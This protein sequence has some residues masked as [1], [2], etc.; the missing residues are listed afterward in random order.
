MA[1]EVGKTRPFGGGILK[2]ELRC[3]V[4]GVGGCSFFGHQLKHPSQAQNRDVTQH[5]PEFYNAVEMVRM[6]CET[7]LGTRFY[8]VIMGEQSNAKKS[9]QKHLCLQTCASLSSRVYRQHESETLPSKQMLIHESQKEKLKVQ[10]PQQKY[11]PKE[12]KRTGKT[13]SGDP[14]RSPRLTLIC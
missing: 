8:F 7:G 4:G 13:V 5:N 9:T 10:T 1:K 3:A 12:A 6:T 11:A 2:K 14:T